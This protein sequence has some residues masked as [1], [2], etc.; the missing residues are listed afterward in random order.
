L[1][2]ECSKKIFLE[3]SMCLKVNSPTMILLRN[4]IY[5]IKTKKTKALCS[6]ISYIRISKIYYFLLFNNRIENNP[7][8]IEKEVI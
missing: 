5:F 8:L 7:S 4:Q 3:I 2:E 6:Q 1:I